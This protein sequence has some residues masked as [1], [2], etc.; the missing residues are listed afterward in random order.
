MDQAEAD[1][2]EL[3]EAGAGGGQRDDAV[4]DGVVGVFRQEFPIP[5]AAGQRRVGA[6]DGVER[7]AE[8]DGEGRACGGGIEFEVVDFRIG[9]RI[10]A[11]DVRYADGTDPLVQ[12]TPAV[13]GVSLPVSTWTTVAKAS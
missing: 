9:R 13:G 7:I 11:P 1:D 5:A 12:A 10:G 4:G 8:G 6:V 2:P 3:G